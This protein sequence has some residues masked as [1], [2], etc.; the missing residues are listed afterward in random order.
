VIAAGVD[1]GSTA[2]K[3]VLIDDNQRILAR[4]VIKTGANVVGGG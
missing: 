3:A 4:S 2:T 1:V